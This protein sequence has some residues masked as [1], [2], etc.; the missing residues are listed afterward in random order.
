MALQGRSIKGT[1]E[2]GLVRCPAVGGDG[3]ESNRAGLGSAHFAAA[4]GSFLD[5]SRC[6]EE[7]EGEWK[8]E[9][10]SLRI[11]YVISHRLTTYALQLR[12]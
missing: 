8:E 5:V 3:W 9:F 10:K 6:T 1:S 4:P 2:G 12:E 11:S 7:L